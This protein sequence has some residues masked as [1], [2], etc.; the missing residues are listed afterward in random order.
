MPLQLNSS[1]RATLA[2]AAGPGSALAM[3]VLVRVAEGMGAGRLL[4]ITGAHVDG[5]LYHGQAGLDFAR[6]LNQGGARVRV[7]TTL[8]VGSL[9]LLHP[10]LV[11]MRDPAPARE[12]MDL[13]VA[14]GC[15][16]T[17]T[18]APYQSEV[19]PGMGEQIAWAE[20]NAIVFANSVLGARTERYGDFI[21]IC[22]AV[23]GRAPAV[24]LHL[25]DGRRPRLVLDFGV[26][27]DCFA[28]EVGYALAGYVVGRIADNRVAWLRGLPASTSEDQLKALGAAAASSGAVGLFHAEGLT[29]EAASLR[30]DPATPVVQVDAATLEQAR[31]SLNTTSASGVDAIALG[32]PHYSLDQ[33][34]RLGD[35]FKGRQSR[36][37]FY[38][39]T[40]REVLDRLGEAALARLSASRVTVVTDTCTYITPILDP[41]LRVVMT[42]SVKWAYYAPTNLG[43]E[44]VFGSVGE[45]V[46]AAL[47]KRAKR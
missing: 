41:S 21:D 20:S 28:D 36:V 44:V 9:D 24:G 14:M 1:D 27:R 2:G 16:A 10:E 33:M 47:A 11:R 35:M 25:D 13:Y 32:T 3:R 26:V 43:V 7:P 19:R 45:C 8:N 29:P 22:A 31:R 46:D 18:C 23:T 6:R 42:D 30:P 38:V 34:Q 12:L 40:S 17:W 5:C 37:P 15:R 4:D 39:N